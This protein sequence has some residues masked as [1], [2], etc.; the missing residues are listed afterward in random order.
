MPPKRRHTNLSRRIRAEVKS[1]IHENIESYQVSG[2]VDQAISTTT[3][4]QEVIPLLLTK[5]DGSANMYGDEIRLQNLKLNW[6]FSQN[7]TTQNYRM[8][9]FEPQPDYDPSTGDQLL[10]ETSAKK[11]ISVLNREYVK[12]VYLDRVVYQ[13]GVPSGGVQ[14]TRGRKF[15]NLRNRLC[16]FKS[17]ATTMDVNV[18]LFLMLVSDSGATSHPIMTVLMNLAYT[19]A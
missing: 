12:R 10:F 4:F 6:E 11:F 16:K 17:P 1:Q 5:S 19:D 7:D 18:K 15:I 3:Y 2:Y 13:G 9:L 8:V 14:V